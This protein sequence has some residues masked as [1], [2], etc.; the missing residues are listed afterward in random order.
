VLPSC[1]QSVTTFGGYGGS[2]YIYMYILTLVVR[3]S[4]KV[5]G[6]VNIYSIQYLSYYK[7]TEDELKN[8]ESEAVVQ[9]PVH[10]VRPVGATCDISDDHGI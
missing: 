1:W 3:Y 8:N 2:Y 9:V 4:S 7:T 10:A 6:I 5:L